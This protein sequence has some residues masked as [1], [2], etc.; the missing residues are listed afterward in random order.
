MQDTFALSL[1]LPS[2]PNTLP[3]PSPNSPTIHGTLERIVEVPSS[4][5]LRALV[6]APFLLVILVSLSL[7]IYMYIFLFPIFSI[8]TRAIS[9]L[10]NYDRLLLD[11]R[12]INYLLSWRIG[13]EKWP[14]MVHNCPPTT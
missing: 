6:V 8:Y 14:L 5:R 2:F 12:E 9:E 7:Y 11:F 13:R 3:L 10:H 4:A 1:L